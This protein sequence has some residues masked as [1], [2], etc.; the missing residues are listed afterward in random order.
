MKYFKYLGLSLLLFSSFLGIA[1]TVTL[2]VDKTYINSSNQVTITATLSSSVSTTTA[3]T[4]ATSGDA[5]T[6]DYAH[7]GT[8]NAV[9]VV[10]GNGQGSGSNQLNHQNGIALDSSGNIYV[11]DAGNRRI[12]KWA[13]NATSGTTVAGG[14]GNGYSL[15]QL[16]D[17]SDVF[18]DASGNI[19]VSDGGYDDVRKFPSNSTSS[20]N[21]TIIAGRNGEGSSLNQLYNP[22]GIYVSSS[23]ELYVTAPYNHRIV[24]FPANSTSSSN[25]TVVAGNNGGGSGSNQFSMPYDLAFD[26]ADNLYVTG[27]G[28]NYRVQK[29]ASGASS[30]TTV[31]GGNG[32][33]SA[34]NQFNIPQWVAIDNF[35][36]LYVTDATAASDTRIQ[37]FPSGSSS[38]TNGITVA[39]SNGNGSNANQIGQGGK[40]VVFD[41][42]NNMYVS[43][44]VNNRVQKFFYNPNIVIAA[45]ATSGTAVISLPASGSS[46]NKI[47]TLTPS[48]SSGA[49]LASSSAIS[50]A[51]NDD[52][53]PT[54]TGVNSTTANGS[55][56]QGDVIA[57]TVGFS[58]VVNVTGTPQITLETGSSDAVVNYSSGSGSSTLTFNYTVASGHSSADLDYV[59]TSS[60]ALNSGTIK[61]AALNAATLTLAT[62]GATNSL[63]ANKALVIDTTVPTVTGV[64]STTANGSYKQGDVI[65]ITV[66]FSEVV[67]V[68][69]TPQ[70]TLE[71]GSSDGVVNYSSGSGSNT[72]TF[73]YTI[74]SGETASDLDY[75]ATSSLA[76]N[77]GT[78]KD[79]ALNAATLTL[80]TPGATNSLGAN[81]ALIIDTTIPTVTGVN[82]TTANDS[83]KPGDVIAITV[84]FSEVVNV[85]G[86]PQLRCSSQL[87]QWFRNKY[88]YLQL[89]RSLRS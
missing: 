58:E 28:G 57:I 13:P 65:A 41:S 7:V 79:A 44:Y 86:T 63:E 84:G 27:V 46:N 88:T 55:Y 16:S 31:A 77:S 75:V 89:H 37:K 43:D 30:G 8:G 14:N 45:G 42:E 15:N 62:P 36:N 74:G 21:G 11:A 33:G 26:N 23:G 64:N 73:N 82:S 59:A 50:L 49:S 35:G 70:L 19:Y 78:I 25:A 34:S 12:Q 67:N 32:R 68:T 17:P 10:G 72:L 22:R 2:S 56:K 71:T 54:V 83:Y 5:S 40:E 52:T 4:F 29:W 76:L 85:T 81:K 47:L 6:S 61:D 87:Q 39:G 3:V 38:S 51:I 1:Q 20:T 9:T 18:V 60:L 80:A 66:G 48:V 53:A 24:K 69:G